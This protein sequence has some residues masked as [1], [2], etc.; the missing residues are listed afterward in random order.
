MKETTI[1]KEN[2]NKMVMKFYI[3]ILNEDTD[4]SKVF[5]EK[6]GE[7]INSPIWKKHTDLLTDFWAMIALHDLT[8]QGNPMMPHFDMGLTRDMFP[9]W[10]KIFFETVDSIYEPDAAIVFKSRAEN[11]ASNFMRNLGL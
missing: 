10:L 2:I 9:I 4:V 7:D 8:Y 6:L 11:I 3:R 5:K 1:T